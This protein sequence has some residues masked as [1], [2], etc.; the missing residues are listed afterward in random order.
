MPAIVT[1]ANSSRDY[2]TAHAWVK[3]RMEMSGA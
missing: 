1:E 2:E 3:K